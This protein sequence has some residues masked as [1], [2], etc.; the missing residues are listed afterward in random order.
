M[1]IQRTGEAR[2]RKIRRIIYSSLAILGVALVTLGLSRLKP[3][4]PRV[5]RSTLYFGVVKRGEMLRQVRGHGTLVPEQIQFVQ[6]STEGRIEKICALAGAPVKADTILVELS[7]PELQQSVFEAEWQLKSAEALYTKTKVQTQSDLLN[8]ESSTATLK[9]DLVL[10]QMDAEADEELCKVGIV[11]SLVMKKSKA[12]AED[13]K[14]R[15]DIELKKIKMNADSA[16]AQMAVQDA[17]VAK[18]RAQLELKKRQ[19]EALK[20]R[21]GIDGVLQ[22]L[23]DTVTLQKG[24]RITPNSILAKV[25]QPT[26][27]KAEIK[28]AET[29]AKD[30]QFNQ[31]AT[32]DTRNG[33]VAGHVTRIDPAAVGGTVTID[34]ALDEALPKGARPDMNVEGTIELDRLANVL[35]VGPPVQCQPDQTMGLFKVINNGK[36][37]VRVKVQLGKSSV[38]AVE[39][40]GGLL[41]GDEII[42]S[43]MAQWDAHDRL[44]ID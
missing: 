17:E 3:A 39:V 33:E 5:E 35:H 6:A 42:L 8:Q 32:V 36:E 31:K 38:S 14:A 21:A 25:V 4:A 29:Q 2:K 26:K 11:P 44:R 7:N 10:A 16:G 13:L 18:Y 27:L 19:F 28:V 43:D 1:D 37:A 22:Q 30:I 9:T 41:E 12:H 23:G 20:V 24:Q 34:V 15:Y 40:V